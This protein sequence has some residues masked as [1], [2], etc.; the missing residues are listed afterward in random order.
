MMQCKI[1]TN[2]KKSNWVKSADY[3]D[4]CRAFVNAALN[5]QVP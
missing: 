4:Y 1:I 5:P 3:K 2:M